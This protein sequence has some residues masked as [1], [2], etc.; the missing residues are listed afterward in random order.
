[1]TLTELATRLNS[2]HPMGNALPAILLMTDDVRLPDPLPAVA[3]LPPGAGVILRHYRDPNRAYLAQEIAALCRHRGLLLLIGGDGH[4]AMRVAAHGV[5]F[6]ERRSPES[7]QWRQRCP[8]WLIT[9]AAHSHKSLVSAVHNGSHAALL[10]PV[11]STESHPDSK[12]LGAVRF[13]ALIKA[14]QRIHR[15]YPVYALGGVTSKTA[16]RIAN[17]GA[18]GVAGISGIARP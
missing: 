17:S 7:R 12:P 5:H 9:A 11:F 13:A 2:R 15:G 3:A 10:G 6:P 1:M 14:A 8:H 18:V 16:R 4:M